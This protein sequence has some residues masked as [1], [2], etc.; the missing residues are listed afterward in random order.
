MKL[1]RL[2]HSRG[3]EHIM[4]LYPRINSQ[5]TF[6]TNAACH[7]FPNSFYCTRECS[8][9]AKK[10]VSEKWMRERGVR[11]LGGEFRGVLWPTFA[12]PHIQCRTLHPF[13]P[14]AIDCGKWSGGLIAIFFFGQKKGESIICVAGIYFTTFKMFK[15]F[16]LDF[17]QG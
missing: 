6:R 2:T 3:R 14:R 4:E 17:F 8:V 9:R 15:I 5:R 10:G 16:L 7:H 13:I 12:P 1:Y 11:G